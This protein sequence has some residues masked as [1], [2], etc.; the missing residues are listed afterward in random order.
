MSL[1]G[2]FQ[3]PDG[4]WQVPPEDSGANPFITYSA[5][6]TPLPTATSA[7]K[8]V[9][10]VVSDATAPLYMTAYASGGTV[11]CSVISTGSAWLTH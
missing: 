3:A 4:S 9:Q 8:G 2:K 7:N 6:G 10:A 11:T 5:A 1:T